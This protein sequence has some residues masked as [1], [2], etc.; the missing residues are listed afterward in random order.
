MNNRKNGFDGKLGLF[1]GMF[2]IVT[3]IL[4]SGILVLP[5]IVF[6]KI[7]RDGIYAW[8]G[9]GALCAPILLTMIILGSAHPS[10]GG[11]AYYT[12]VHG[13]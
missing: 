1:T 2:L 11:V 8:I 10:A 9:C 13:S 12:N 7:G 4:G 6:E 3:I 5:G